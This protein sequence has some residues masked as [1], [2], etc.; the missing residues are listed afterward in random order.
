MRH[1]PLCLTPSAWRDMPHTHPCGV[2]DGRGKQ[3][4]CV[5]SHCGGK[6]VLW[7]GTLPSAM[8]FYTVAHDTDGAALFC[9]DNGTPLVLSGTSREA[10]NQHMALLNVRQWFTNG[11]AA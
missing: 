10:E 7:D 11:G 6:G 2:C 8:E 5:C 1:I 4:G 9:D 3:L